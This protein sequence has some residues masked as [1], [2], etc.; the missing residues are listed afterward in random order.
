MTLTT[1]GFEAW[2]QLK[3]QANYRIETSTNLAAWQS[4]VTLTNATGTVR[5]LDP[6]ANAIAKK[7][8]RAV[9]E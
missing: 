8:Y 4:W 7:F 6:S 1:N 5:V 9:I 3:I 2:L